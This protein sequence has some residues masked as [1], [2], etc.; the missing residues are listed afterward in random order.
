MSNFYEALTT[1]DSFTDNGRATNSTSGSFIVDFFGAMGS[2]R[3]QDLSGLFARAFGESEEL[4]VRC[5]LFLRDPRG[6]MGERAQFRN[7][8]VELPEAIAQRVIQKIPEIGRYDDLS[9]FVGTKLEE[10]AMEVWVSAITVERN[11]LAAKWAPRKGP[12]KEAMRKYLG[13][14]PKVLRKLLVETTN[15]VENKM[16][17]RQWDEIEYDKLPSRAQMIYRKAFN[18]H[19]PEGY[20]EY[21]DKLEKGEAKIN[22]AVLYPHEIVHSIKQVSWNLGTYTSS[23]L[24]EAQWKALPD[25]VKGMKVLPMVDVSGS[26]GCGA[27]RGSYVTCMD[28]ALALGLYCSD[29]SSEAFRDLMLT[30]SANPR[31]HKITGDTLADKLN[32]MCR[33]DWDMNTDI[34]AALSRVITHA[35]RHDVPKEDMPEVL[36]ILSDMEFDA[37]SRYGTNDTISQ[38]VTRRYADSKYD[39]PRI[40]FWNLNARPGNVPIKVRDSGM[41][42]VSG[43]SP[44]VMKAVLS[45]S[46][47]DPL[48]LVKDTV[49]VPKYNY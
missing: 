39:M 17:A 46:R 32:G 24:A 1:G 42:T 16:C 21:L 20:Q 45:N 22:S 11:G 38:E 41:A 35:E 12:V 29:R 48:Q 33:A 28:V 23:T 19:D 8:V 40:V 18:R 15:V 7:L 6:G 44:A 37:A 2:S 3:G 10:V 13:V 4:A 26:M 25:Y 34:S 14:S 31:L 9:V 36:L 43:F 5:L 49:C 47:F 30:F 27:G